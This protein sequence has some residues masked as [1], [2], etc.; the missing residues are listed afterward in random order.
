MLSCHVDNQPSFHFETGG[1]GFDSLQD[2]Y[3]FSNSDRFFPYPICDYGRGLTED[4][5]PFIEDP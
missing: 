3:S 1:S 5:A 4:G 2:D